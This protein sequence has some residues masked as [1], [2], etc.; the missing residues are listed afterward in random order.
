A[1]TV[2][3]SWGL[4]SHHDN[5]PTPT[6][7]NVQQ[8]MVNLFA[9]MGVQ[10]ATLMQSLAVAT[11]ST[12]HIAPTTTITAPGGSLSAAQTYTI[13][14]TA[15][16]TGGGLVAVVEVSTDGGVTWHRANG[17]DNW[18]YSWTPLAP[19]AYTIKSRAVDDS[20]NLET[21]GAGVTV[22]VSNGG[23]GSLFAPNET[24]AVPFETDSNPL[25][26]GV[27]FSS[28]QSGSIVGLRYYKGLGNSGDHL[29][30]L[31]TSTGT[32]LA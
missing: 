1:G 17:Y 2:Y 29:G 14:G 5:E 10:P 13:S 11:Q 25:T 3:W 23:A 30:S 9:E 28:T 22:N 7:P 16:D 15:T 24:P 8:A 18:T 31:W 26:V 21:P 20:I 12:D 19:G 32:L 4:D 27:R 6:D